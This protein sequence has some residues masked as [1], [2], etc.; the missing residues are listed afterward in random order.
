VHDRRECQRQHWGSHK[1]QCRLLTLALMSASTQA[2][3]AEMLFFEAAT[4]QTRGAAG[5]EH[6]VIDGI[7]LYSLQYS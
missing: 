3:A 7:L 5:W 1:A 4:V 2:Q 6:F